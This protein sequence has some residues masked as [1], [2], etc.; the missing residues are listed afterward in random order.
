MHES[1]KQA[2]PK[3]TRWNWRPEG[4]AENNPLFLWPVDWRA[5]ARWYLHN[6]KPNSEYAIFLF[7]ALLS[8]FYLQP[9]LAVMATAELA[10]LSAEQWAWI[11]RVYLRNLCYVLVFAG[12]LHLYFYTFMQQGQEHKYEARMLSADSSRF[13]FG[14][15]VWDNMFWTLASGVT[16]WTLYEVILLT[17]LAQGWAASTSWQ[18]N[19]LWFCAWFL[20]IPLWLSLHFYLGH[21]LLHWPPLY[22][23]SHVVHH[24][25]LNTGPWSGISM[26]PIEHLI[27]LSS[28]LIHLF[29][30]SHPLHIF[31]HGYALTLSAIF[32][33]TGFDGLI[34][35]GKQWLA[36]GHFHHQLHHRHFE[37][38]YGAAELPCDAWAGTFDDGSPEA[39]QRLREVTRDRWM[40]NKQ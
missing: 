27:Y 6:W 18:Q 15:Q 21:R 40:Q 2:L 17:A 26:H 29:I 4:P 31:F 7:C 32:G 16:I 38:N 35:R 24:R 19:P 14:K 36:I 28:M 23:I 13:T 8:W 1:V 30:P 39:R 10:G 11:G 9:D 12:G 25:N 3:P 33:H 22:R 5:S 34:V 37:C 20:I